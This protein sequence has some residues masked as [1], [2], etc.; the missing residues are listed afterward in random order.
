MLRCLA[1]LGLL[2][3]GAAPVPPAPWPLEAYV[4]WQ[5]EWGARD[6]EA[7]RL[8]V[9]VEPKR[10]GEDRPASEACTRGDLYL[11][12]TVSA[13]GKA[14]V[15]LRGE[16]GVAAWIGIGKLAATDAGPSAILISEDGGSA[17]CVQI[18]VAAARASGFRAA[19]L[20]AD[21]RDHGTICG[22]DPDRLA[23]PQD[24]T[25][26]GRAEFLLRDPRFYCA[27]TSCAGTWYPPRVIAFDGARSLDVSGDPALLP[28]YRADM[29]RARAACERE[30][31]EAQGACAGY[32]ADAARLGR[33]DEAWAVVAAQVKRGCRVPAPDGCA[34]VD[35]IPAD[36]PARL[37]TALRKGQ[38]DDLKPVTPI[39]G[40]STGPKGATR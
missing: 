8:R 4:R 23:W 12:A 30:T 15:T 18:D 1:L 32:A 26:H 7:G 3:I 13:P 19:R 39:H 22:V 35:R 28:L 6:V 20:T 14:P 9:R 16:P 10:C 24:R 31:A 34:D 21:A 17:G 27:F 33:L 5:P 37:A 2:S 11:E 36:F 40:S 25:G 38:R 29:A